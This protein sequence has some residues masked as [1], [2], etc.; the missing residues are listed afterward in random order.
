MVKRG[1][2][3][4]P[5]GKTRYTPKSLMGYFK[6]AEK[7]VQVGHKGLKL[8]R[9][10]K[11]TF[12]SSP[13]PT[14]SSFNMLQGISQHNDH[15][16]YKQ[17]ILKRKPLRNRGKGKVHF[18]LN[19]DF[20]ASASEGNQAVLQLIELNKNMLNGST[21]NVANAAGQWPATIFDFD[22]N[23]KITSNS[24][25]VYSASAAGASSQNPTQAVNLEKVTQ[26]MNLYNPSS[27]PLT[28]YVYWFMTIKSTQKSPFDLW[29]DDLNTEGQFNANATTRGSF[30]QTTTLLGKANQFYYGMYPNT[31]SLRRFYKLLRVNK[32]VLQGGDS[33][34]LNTTLHINR[35]ILEETLNE[36]TVDPIPGVSFYPMIIAQGGP[37]VATD[38]SISEVTY[39]APKIGVILSTK[40]TM[41]FRKEQTYLRGNFIKVDYRVGGAVANEKVVDDEDDVT[42]PQYAL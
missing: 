5:K 6:T 23:N 18:T 25:P 41:S 40:Y 11:N 26:K 3:A 20:T 42:Q 37:C 19:R 7:A 10:Y 16:E 9:D 13:S 27:V 4:K 12:K 34:K 24:G 22:P 14:A 38:T 15:S 32:F 35:C 36:M 33:R 39:A 2:I 31:P 29:G 17:T 21:T 8:Y 30:A 28:V 1:K